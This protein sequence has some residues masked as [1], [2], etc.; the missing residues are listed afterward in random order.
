MKVKCG[1]CKAKVNLKTEEVKTMVIRFNCPVCNAINKLNLET[2]KSK[3]KEVT[4]EKTQINTDNSNNVAGWLVVHDENTK[5]QTHTLKMGKN[6]VGRKSESKLCEVMID[7]E[8]KYMSRNHFA[9]EVS[10]GT[11]GMEY[12]VYDVTS[13]NGTFINAVK[14]NKL[15]QKDKVLLS[16]GDT[17]QAGRTKMVLRIKKV[18]GTA[19]I[20]TNTVI[21]MKHLKTIIAQ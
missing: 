1:K 6:I 15:N 8:D 16:D 10:L 20:A 5:Q 21:S 11:K 18:A 3:Q 4:D 19:K 9:V 14:E 13:T 7:T 12:M 2:A 17:I